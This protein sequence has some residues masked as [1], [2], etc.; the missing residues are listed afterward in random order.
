ML[1]D[2]HKIQ[3]YLFS[4]GL[5]RVLILRFLPSD[6]TGWYN[7]PPI[8]S[9]PLDVPIKFFPVRKRALWD[10]KKWFSRCVSNAE[11]RQSAFG[12][13]L[14]EVGRQQFP[15]KF[16]PTVKKYGGMK[17]SWYIESTATTIPSSEINIVWS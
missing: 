15:D 7:H 1:Y 2:C 14:P 10:D 6:L 17:Q 13:P 12:S 5:L 4:G 11:I 16:Y 8:S 3:E 9:H